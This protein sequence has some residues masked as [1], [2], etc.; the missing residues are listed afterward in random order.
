MLKIIINDIFLNFRVYLLVILLVNASLQQ[1]YLKY[2]LTLDRRQKRLILTLCAIYIK[3]L[4]TYLFF[5]K[6]YSTQF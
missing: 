2:I 6:K 1:K 4:L 5:Y 3:V